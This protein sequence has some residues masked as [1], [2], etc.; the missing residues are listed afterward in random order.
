MK[1]ILM[2]EATQSISASFRP[3]APPS[4]KGKVMSKVP[5]STAKELAAL[6][7]KPESE[8]DFS[9][10]PATTGNDW[11]GAVRGKFYRP[12][13]QQLTVRIDA[14]VIEW[15]KS[16]GRGYQSRLNDILRTAM[17]DKA[18]HPSLK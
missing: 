11:H 13:K 7:A 2:K 6:A 16:Q 8:I 17:R 1:P 14:D 9:D 18:R 4:W 3:G 12:I 15:L 5:E 10:L